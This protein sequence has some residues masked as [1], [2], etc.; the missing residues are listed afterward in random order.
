MNRIIGRVV[1]V[2]FLML[3]GAGCAFEQVSD[4]GDPSEQNDDASDAVS[5]ITSRDERLGARRPAALER[6]RGAPSTAP[7]CAG[8]GP[9]PDPW[10]K[11]GPLPDPWTSSSSGGPTTSGGSSDGKSK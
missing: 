4:E 5:F 7:V 1:L 10:T 2:T 8:C 9:L 11:F 3:F 6:R